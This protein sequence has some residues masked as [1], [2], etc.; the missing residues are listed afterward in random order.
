M[1][2]THHTFKKIIIR[3][4]REKVYYYIVLEIFKILKYNYTSN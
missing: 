4:D 3:L 2:D 1:T